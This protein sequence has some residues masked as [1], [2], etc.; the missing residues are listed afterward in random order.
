MVSNSVLP[1]ASTVWTFNIRKRYPGFPSVK[2]TACSAG[3]LR[4]IR[5][6]ERVEDEEREHREPRL[7]G[8]ADLYTLYRVY[9]TL[10]DTT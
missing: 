1:F 8:R 7:H 3:D 10:F 9:K 2:S 4:G 6:E 5:E